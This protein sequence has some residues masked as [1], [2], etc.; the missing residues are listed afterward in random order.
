MDFSNLKKV[1]FHKKTQIQSS[2]GLEE[3]FGCTDIHFEKDAVVVFTGSA[4]LAPEFT[5]EGLVK[6][7]MTSQLIRGVS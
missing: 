5:S 7:V 2:K 4:L 1:S 6:L 3:A